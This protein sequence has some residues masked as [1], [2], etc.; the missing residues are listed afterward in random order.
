MKRKNKKRFLKNQSKFRRI[1]IIFVCKEEKHGKIKK[2]VKNL[3]K[4]DVWKNKEEVRQ[5]IPKVKYVE[6]KEKEEQ[7]KISDELH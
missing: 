3:K 1:L 4:K 5:I 2:T 7:R 6:L